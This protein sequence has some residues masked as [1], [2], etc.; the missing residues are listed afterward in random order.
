[1]NE[2]KLRKKVSKIIK[3]DINL[4]ECAGNSDVY[5]KYPWIKTCNTSERWEEC[6]K[7]N[8]PDEHLREFIF[9]VACELG[10]IEGKEREK[11]IISDD[12]IKEIME[13]KQ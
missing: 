9:N 8:Y 6:L 12:A 3:N 4:F 11:W 7:K 5:G 1:M 2:I 10:Y 13:N